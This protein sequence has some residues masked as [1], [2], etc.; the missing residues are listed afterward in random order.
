MHNRLKQL[1]KEKG[2]TLDEIQNQTG[3][4]RGT[5]NNYEAGKTEPKLETWQKLADFFGVSVPYLQGIETETYTDKDL[6]K[7]LYEAY[8]DDL[9][10]NAYPDEVIKLLPNLKDKNYVIYS[11]KEIKKFYE[12]AL[13]YNLMELSYV[14][15]EVKANEDTNNLS[16]IDIE[17]IVSEIH[18]MPTIEGLTAT[19]KGAY[20]DEA[21]KRI[22]VG[23]IREINIA[24]NY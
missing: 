11:R 7:L 23:I 15:K 10:F 19:K 1:R 9:S 16:L 2:L 21:I 4:K 8:R 22:I 13:L 3:I 14:D 12:K 20:S 6:S 17:N 18:Y 5:F 24:L